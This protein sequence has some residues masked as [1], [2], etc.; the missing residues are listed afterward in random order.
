MRL[1][2]SSNI[3][4]SS[5]DPEAALRLIS[6]SGFT[7]IMWGHHWNT[8]FAYGRYEL[9]AIRSMLRRYGL[10]L[11]D[12]HGCANAEK[13]WFSV[14]E[15][16]RKAGIELILNR[17]RMMKHL[18]ATGVLVMQQPRIK[19][20][21]TAEEIAYNRRQFDSLRR[22]MDDI[23]PHLEKLDARIALEN[24]PGDTWEF[25]TCLLDNYPAERFGFCF[26]SGHANIA[27]RPQFAECE[28]YKSRIRSVHLHDNDGTGDQH[29]A[30]FYGTVDWQRVAR[31]L[32]SSGYRG[33]INF[34]LHIQKS[35]FFTP[36]LPLTAQPAERVRAY[37]EDTYARCARFGN[38]CRRGV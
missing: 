2:V 33:V 7:H 5:G 31:M 30:P 27:L 16:Q 22:S 28:K 26:D 18:D 32:D 15:Y 8:D 36:E 35:R 3:L 17:I 4:A 23:L 13:S 25:L 11:Q 34:E 21:S 38:M 29:L 37:L 20:D 10:I 24:M 1:S 14:L 19:A 6:E 12:V 9:A